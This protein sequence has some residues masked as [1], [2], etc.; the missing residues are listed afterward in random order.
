VIP[1]PHL[2]QNLARSRLLVSRAVASVG[3]GER[4][5]N[6][7]GAGMEFAAHREYAPGDDLRHLDTHVLA[8]TGQ[9]YMR[10]YEVHMQ[11]PVTI[12]VDG[13]R[14]MGQGMPSKLDTAKWLANILGFVALAGGDRARI[15]FWDGLRLEFSPFYQGANRVQRLFLWVA[16]RQTASTGS[17]KEAFLPAAESMPSRSLVILLSDWWVEDFEADIKRLGAN[18]RELWALQIVSREELDPTLLGQGDLRLIDSESGDEVEFS[19][20]ALSATSYR[21][22]VDEWCDRLRRRVL[23]LQGRYLL[24]RTDDVLEKI[25]WQDMRRLGMVR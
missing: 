2:L 14:S 1:P 13:S 5:S 15:G 19:L 20:D 12:L 18:D 16:S 4:R 9:Y 25:V 21:R 3:V 8:R 6:A 24:I 23:E 10:Q 22:T 11:L 7:K 17:F